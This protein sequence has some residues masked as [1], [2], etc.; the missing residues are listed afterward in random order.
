[1]E[2]KGLGWTPL[3]ARAP[4]CPLSLD[5]RGQSGSCHGGVALSPELAVGAPA[6]LVSAITELATLLEL[7]TLSGVGWGTWMAGEDQVSDSRVLTP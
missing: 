3:A 6:V 2:E 5:G 7:G 4:A 1:M